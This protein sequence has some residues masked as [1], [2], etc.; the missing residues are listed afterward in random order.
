MSN[1]DKNTM[2][3]TNLRVEPDE[4]GLRLVETH[5]GTLLIHRATRIGSVG[6]DLIVGELGNWRGRWRLCV[7]I[8]H[9]EPW[10]KDGAQAYVEVGVFDN[11]EQAL[12]ALR[13]AA[14]NFAPRPG[15]QRLHPGV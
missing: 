4:L 8:R 1:D 6:A 11:V 2:P 12:F 14:A 3:F 7:P 9:V 15:E 5:F 10:A 13:A